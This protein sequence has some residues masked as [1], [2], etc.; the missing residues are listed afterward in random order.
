MTHGL[1]GKE[2]PDADAAPR[3]GAGGRVVGE[4][5]EG[6]GQPEGRGLLVGGLERALLGPQAQVVVEDGPLFPAVL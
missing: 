3:V 6:R 4:R 5:G 2:V 1:V